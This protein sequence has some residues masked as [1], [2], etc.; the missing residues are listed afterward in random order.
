MLP[1]DNNLNNNNNN[2]NDFL[3]VK[4]EK[5]KIKA[6]NNSNQVNLCNFPYL[7]QK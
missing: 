7:E 6:N 1:D 3:P 5:A 2:S 4:Q